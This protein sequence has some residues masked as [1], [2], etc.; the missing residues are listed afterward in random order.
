MSKRFLNVLVDSAETT[1]L[2]KLFHIATIL[3]LKSVYV[4]YSASGLIAL[5][6]YI[7]LNVIE[8]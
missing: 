8:T 7:T 1:V 6:K 5:Y 2:G 4:G 3:L